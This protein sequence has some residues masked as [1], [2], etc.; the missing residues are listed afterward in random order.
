MNNL[1]LRFSQEQPVNQK[2]YQTAQSKFGLSIEKT[3]ILHTQNNPNER[4]T[5]VDI[6]AAI[7]ASWTASELDR[8]RNKL[9]KLQRLA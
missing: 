2:P 3:K 5:I 6:T 4:R 1:I 9:T 7:T 8:W